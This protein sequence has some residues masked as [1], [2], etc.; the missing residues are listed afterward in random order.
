MF[1][2]KKKDG[3]LPPVICGV[4]DSIYVVFW[5]GRKP[6]IYGRDWTHVCS[7]GDEIGNPADM[8]KEQKKN[9]VK[10][11]LEELRSVK[12]EEV[13]EKLKAEM[14]LFQKKQGEGWWGTEST[15]VRRPRA[16]V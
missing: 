13:W 4:T 8:D 11:V 5:Q 6:E 10:E 3:W 1:F 14:V 16:R 12:G 7:V 2:N 15:K 9:A